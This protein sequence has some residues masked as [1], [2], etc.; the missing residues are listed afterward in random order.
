MAT[1]NQ[2]KMNS[3]LKFISDLPPVFTRQDLLE[4]IVRDK[5]F[6]ISKA[7]SIIEYGVITGLLIRI[8]RGTYKQLGAE[9]GF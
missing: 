7:N 6:S 4:I 5:G 1:L 2:V 8:G 9:V 3:N